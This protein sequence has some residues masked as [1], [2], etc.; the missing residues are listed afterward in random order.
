MVDNIYH[1]GINI[2]QVIAEPKDQPE[3]Q[4]ELEEVLNKFNVGESIRIP[5]QD[6][7]EDILPG[8]EIVHFN[9]PVAYDRNGIVVVLSKIIKSGHFRPPHDEKLP[10]LSFED[11]W[12]AKVIKFI[13]S[14]HYEDIKGDCLK[15]NIGG[16]HDVTSLKELILRR[17]KKTL[18][19]LSDSE[20]L[21]QGL[22]VTFLKLLGR[23]SW[24]ETVEG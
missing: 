5:V 21:D 9:L 8:Q 1:R 19:H 6:Y 17:Y 4:L 2:K 11:I 7:P 23:V 16:V 20:I 10:V 3:R 18:P 14:I 13:P 12:K 24:H 22:S 15:N